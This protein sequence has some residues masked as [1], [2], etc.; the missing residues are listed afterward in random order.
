[1]CI[2]CG[3]NM[4]KKESNVYSK[5][6]QFFIGMPFATVVLEFFIQFNIYFTNFFISLISPALWEIKS[7]IIIFYK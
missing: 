1:M 4:V 6:N 2:S 3:T 7:T 5:P